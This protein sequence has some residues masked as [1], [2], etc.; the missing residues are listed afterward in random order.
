MRKAFL[1]LLLALVP[2]L[3]CAVDIYSSN[4]LMQKLATLDAL[5]S[6]GY[7]LVEESDSAATLYLDGKAV[8]TRTVS[9]DGEGQTITETDLVS[10]QVT[11]R[12]YTDGR[13]V[14]EIISDM[15]GNA[16]RS[17]YY[18][19]N[20]GRLSFVTTTVAGSEVTETVFFLRS[21]D[22]GEPF[23]VRTDKGIRF[24][25]S[26]WV[27]Q[28][29]EL[30]EM[31]S[32][33]LILKGEHSQDEK[34]N[35]VYKEGGREYIYLPDGRIL[36]VTEGTT[37]RSYIYEED[38]LVRVETATGNLLSV[39]YYTNGS[40]VRRVDYEDGELTSETELRKDGN[41]R[42]LYSKGRQVAT[43]YYR[44]DNR[45]VDRIEYN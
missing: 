14:S 41:I 35:I 29:G 12:R 9:N 21:S 36:S 43:V 23:A 33:N 20:G 37:V 17:E 45:T 26:S 6:Q 4:Q 13:L 11:K 25:A 3:L 5:P 10:A 34:G 38:R 32:T 15:E 39:E 8:M 42:K 1:L 2:A 27:Y 19:Y 16:F 40:A 7:A 18:G 44:S 24:F 31:V 22:T 28:E 30:F